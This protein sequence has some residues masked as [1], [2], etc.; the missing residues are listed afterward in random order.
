MS[1]NATTTNGRKNMKDKI[2]VR[3]KAKEERKNK[4]VLLL[5]L[6]FYIIIFIESVDLP[7]HGTLFSSKVIY[8]LL[9]I[10]N[11]SLRIFVKIIYNFCIFDPAC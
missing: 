4:S 8:Y 10:V 9:F 2:T 7:A 11:P 1:D 5:M 6:N 3:G